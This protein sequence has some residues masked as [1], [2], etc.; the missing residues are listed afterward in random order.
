MEHNNWNNPN[1]T[2]LYF[3]YTKVKYADAFC[4][5]GSIK[6]GTLKE[7]TT[8]Y[9]KE[10]IKGRGD[11][12]EGT[13]GFANKMDIVNVRKLKKKYPEAEKM[14]FNNDNNVYFKRKRS[15]Q[16]PSYCLYNVNVEKFK[17][18]EQTGWQKTSA[19]IP[20]SYFK[21]FIDAE[22]FGN[23]ENLPYEERP[24]LIVI[25]NTAEFR[26][27]I[28]KYLMSIGCKEEEIIISPIEYIDFTEKGWL[29]FNQ[30]EPNELFIKSSEFKRQS[31]IRVVV[32]TDNQEVLDILKK[33]C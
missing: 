19:S 25:N 28:I 29:D 20:P 16:L 11:P 5:K 6:F 10:Q 1:I 4:K 13:I 31:E 15:L 17:V 9:E 2:L 21:D 32:N 26:N 14:M 12:Y 27:R 23:I 3:R 30:K 22:D 18:P 7:W 33:T 24:A 8:V